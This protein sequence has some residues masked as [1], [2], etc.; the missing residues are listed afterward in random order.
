MPLAS[1]AG[2]ANAKKRTFF[3]ST[4]F[5]ER[6]KASSWLLATFRFQ[7]SRSKKCDHFIFSSLRSY[8]LGS[9]PSC[10]DLWGYWKL[11][12]EKPHWY[13]FWLCHPQ[14]DIMGNKTQPQKRKWLTI[15]DKSAIKWRNC[16]FLLNL[17]KSIIAFDNIDSILEN[18]YGQFDVALNSV[19]IY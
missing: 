2:N 10:A 17:L 18:D 6:K 8:K 11:M 7:L 13:I 5:F 9:L 14:L 12:W 19:V 4:S 16:R 1:L 15:L 3:T